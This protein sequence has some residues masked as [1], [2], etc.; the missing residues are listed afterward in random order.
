MK[1]DG[2]LNALAAVLSR[3]RTEVTAAYLFGST[4][5][6]EA[7]KLSDIDVAVLSSAEKSA[8]PVDLRFRLQADL[9]RALHRSDIDLLILNTMSNLILKDEI[10][11]NGLL[12]Y[13]GDSEAREEFEIR[14]IHSC[15][16]FRRQ[17]QEAIGF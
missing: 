13:D 11:R 10:I 5:K 2:I 4:A 1:L 9:C 15:I 3:Y 17:R 6:G 12:V 14:V 7:G 16:D 8:N